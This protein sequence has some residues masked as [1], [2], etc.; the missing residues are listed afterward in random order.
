MSIRLV[1][2]GDDAGSA[3]AANQAVLEAFRHGIMK[4][5]SIMVPGPH[6]EHAA[7]LLAGETGLC[8]G[9]HTTLNAEWDR[10]RWGP[11]SPRGEVPSLIRSDGSFF[12]TPRALHENAPLLEEI[13]REIQAQLDRGRALGFDFRYADMHMGWA[14]VAEGVQER[15]IRWCE[16]EGLINNWQTPWIEP[17]AEAEGDPVDRLIAALEVVPPGEYVFVGH[18]AYDTEEMRALSHEGMPGER[19]ARERDWDRRLFTDPRILAFC[20][21]RGIVPTRYDEL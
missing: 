17:Q 8:C 12:P 2:R 20:R 18:P 9:L 3:R 21:E 19:V 13:F 15:W 16:R 5:A 6:I 11:V 14:W 4:N 10:V 1:T 7:E